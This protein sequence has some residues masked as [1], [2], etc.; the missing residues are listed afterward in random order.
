MTRVVRAY[1]ETDFGFVRSV[2]AAYLEEERRR[3]PEMGVGDD[4]PDSYLPRLIQ[5]TQNE[6]GKFLVALEEGTRCG[7]IAALPKEAQPWDQ[8]RKKTL[9]IMEAHVDAAFRRRGIGRELFSAIEQAFSC[10][11]FDWSTLGTFAGNA[12]A[13]AFYR[14]MGY[15]A[16]YQFMGKKIGGENTNDTPTG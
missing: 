8:T 2:F 10:D 13:H 5:K 6:G 7:F 14:S 4:F 12:Q 1:E 16:T 3:V 11:G 15:E 9:M